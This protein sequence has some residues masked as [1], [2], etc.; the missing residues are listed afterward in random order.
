[1]LD[2]DLDHDLEGLDPEQAAG[3]AASAP[4]S[5][6]DALRALA[7]TMTAAYPDVSADGETRRQIGDT[8][9]GYRLLDDGKTLKVTLTGAVEDAYEI[10]GLS[11]LAYNL[12]EF[13]AQAMRG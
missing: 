10:H 8:V 13:I 11:A 4:R 7:D 9:L 5:H 12:R 1:M 3:V 2:Y 6:G